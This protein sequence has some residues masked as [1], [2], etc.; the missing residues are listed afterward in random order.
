MDCGAVDS[1]NFEYMFLSLVYLTIVVV[2][3][4]LQETKSEFSDAWADNLLL[5]VSI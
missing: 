1:S 2:H 4:V 5:L 3:N